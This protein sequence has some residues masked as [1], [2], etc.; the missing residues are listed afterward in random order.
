MRRIP[1]TDVVGVR[2]RQICVLIA[3]AV[4]TALALSPRG[5]SAYTILGLKIRRQIVHHADLPAPNHEG[6]IGIAACIGGRL[7]SIDRRWAMFYLTNTMVCVRRYGGASGGAGLLER[8]STTSLDWEQVGEIGETCEQGTA[9]ASDTVLRDLG[10]VSF[11]TDRRLRPES[12]LLLSGSMAVITPHG[13]GRLRLGRRA[14]SLRRQHLIVS[15]RKGCEIDVGQRAA[16]LGPPLEGWAIFADGANRLTSLSIE[17]GVR[18]VL[19]IGVGS[20]AAEAR[21]AY[22]AADWDSPREMYPLPVGVLWVEGIDHPKFSIVVD[23][24]THRVDSI[25][26]PATN[27]CE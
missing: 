13:V 20:T 17:G 1:G 8:S 9:G 24:E 10:C 14:G 11:Y 25:A 22:P 4:F 2:T 27:F 12:R 19:G 18:T 15:L 7:S 26:V 3:L 5:A 16:P 6:T 23:P 21:A